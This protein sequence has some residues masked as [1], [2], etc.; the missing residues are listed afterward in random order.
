MNQ[1]R[2]HRQRT[3]TNPRRVIDLK[4]MKVMMIDGEGNGIW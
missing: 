1:L 2:S 3:P 4:V